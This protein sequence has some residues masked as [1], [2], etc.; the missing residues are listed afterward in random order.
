MTFTSSQVTNAGPSSE[1]E[2][3]VAEALVVWL[4]VDA[5]AV[6]AGVAALGQTL[7]DVG[8]GLV[9]EGIAPRFINFIF[10]QVHLI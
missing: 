9:V 2:P 4:Q 1:L 8:A 5:V 6:Q 3:L 10:Y 7:V